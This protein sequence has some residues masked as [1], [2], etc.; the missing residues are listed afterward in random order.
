MKKNI[1]FLLIALLLSCFS[2]ASVSQ[3][4]VSAQQLVVGRIDHA[5]NTVV[6]G[7]SFYKMSLGLKVYKGGDLLGKKRVVNRYALKEGQPVR[8]LLRQQGTVVYV[9]TINILEP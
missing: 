6:I 2:V 3:G 9:D 5:K 8:V 7:D 4:D 1:K